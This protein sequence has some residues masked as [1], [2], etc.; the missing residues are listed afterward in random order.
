MLARKG[1]ELELERQQEH[2][3][4][5]RSVEEYVREHKLDQELQ[6]LVN[7]LVAERP[8]RPLEHLGLLL[9]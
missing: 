7:A 1:A 9:R 5:R 4:R 8:E 2:A 6:S 3:D